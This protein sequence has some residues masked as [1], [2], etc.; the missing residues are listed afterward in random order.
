MTDAKTGAPP[1]DLVVAAGAIATMGARRQILLDGAVAIRGTRIVAV[2]K[3]DTIL[4]RYRPD[5]LIDATS[6]SACWSWRRSSR[7]SGGCRRTT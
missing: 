1:A 6:G 5:T 4:A 3:R 7:M 2:G